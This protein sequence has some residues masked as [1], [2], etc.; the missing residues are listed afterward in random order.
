[1][2]IIEWNG[3]DL[4]EALGK[5]PAGRYRVEPIGD[6]LDLTPDEEDGLTQA[7]DSLRTG[8]GLDHE[9]VRELVL[10]RVGR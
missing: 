10:G 7:L 8:R 3:A 5:L 1:V 2:A 4:P 6:A 9:A